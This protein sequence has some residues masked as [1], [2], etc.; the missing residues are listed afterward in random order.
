MQ[1]VEV[2]SLWLRMHDQRRYW[3]CSRVTKINSSMYNVTLLCMEKEHIS[4]TLPVQYLMSAFKCI[5]KCE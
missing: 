2:G 5:A 3:I 4:I 1:Q